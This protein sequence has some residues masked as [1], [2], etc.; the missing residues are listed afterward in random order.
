MDTLKKPKKT[1]SGL[2]EPVKAKGVPT[3]PGTKHVA[4]ESGKTQAPATKPVPKE[5]AAVKTQG[6]PA[7]ATKPVAAVAKDAVKKQ[8]VVKAKEKGKVKPKD[9]QPEPTPTSAQDSDDIDDIFADAKSKKAKAVVVQETAEF[10]QRI[11]EMT[12][13]EE[14]FFDCR[15]KKKGFRLYALL[16]SSEKD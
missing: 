2:P 8:D 16:T 6:V 11:Y 1:P 12:P 15:R 14:A 7:P 4:K 3:A 9:V 5:A 10:Q 13:E